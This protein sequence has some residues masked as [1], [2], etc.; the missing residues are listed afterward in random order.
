MSIM[1]TGNNDVNNANVL[2]LLCL[3]NADY[4]SRV[5]SAVWRVVAFQKTSSTVSW[6]WEGEQ[7]AALTCD[8]KMSDFMT[9]MKAIDID[10]V[11]LCPGRFLQLT[12]QS[13]GR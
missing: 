4:D 6:L 12:A 10:T 11:T 8:I 7:P 2:F 13:G 9:D 1:F 5:M 3:D